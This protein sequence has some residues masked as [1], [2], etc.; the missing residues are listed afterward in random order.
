MKGSTK[1]LIT[2]I[3][4]PALLLFG[5]NAA[6]ANE[7]ISNLGDGDIM[8]ACVGSQPQGVGSTSRAIRTEQQ[9]ICF[10]NVK[11]EERGNS[12]ATAT[13]K[14][15]ASARRLGFSGSVRTT[16]EA[17]TSNS[18]IS[19]ISEKSW[20]KSLTDYCRESNTRNYGWHWVT[21]GRIFVAEG[22]FACHKGGRF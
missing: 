11:I 10:A 3:A 8:A 2:A 16:L 1:F 15:K 6:K 21:N 18:Y 20:T 14:A 7:K 19:I 13:A 12:N 22:G 4:I 9:A 17:G 5:A